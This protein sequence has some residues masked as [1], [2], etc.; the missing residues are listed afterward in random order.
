M[1]TVDSSTV[2]F[3]SNSSVFRF[4]ITCKLRV[5]TTLDILPVRSNPGG[6]PISLGVG[7]SLF[8]II[9]N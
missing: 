2:S 9:L 7:P 3:R 6:P 8:C 4:D 5:P 1:D